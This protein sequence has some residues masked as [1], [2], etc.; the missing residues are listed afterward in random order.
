MLA[1]LPPSIDE[2]IGYSLGGRVALG[3]LQAAPER[4]RRATLI[5]AHPGLTDPAARARRR[6]ADRRWIELLRQQGIGAF[7]EAW[8]QLPLFATQARVAPAALA[9]QRD[10]RLTQD[11]E[12]LAAALAVLGLGEMPPTWRTLARHPGR[13]RW[14]VGAR[15]AKFLALARR[16]ATLR[17][18]LEL[19]VVSGAGH[20]PLIETPTRLDALL[21]PR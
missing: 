17:P 20:N 13:L 16:V 5:S 21:A 9:R 12:G 18:R 14:I 15:D 4:F 6:A 7:V 3:L 1:Q 19:L 8:E 2:L 11:P 10:R